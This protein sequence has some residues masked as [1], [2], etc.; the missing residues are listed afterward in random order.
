MSGRRG[1][2]KSGRDMDAAAAASLPT[3]SSGGSD[4]TL[5]IGSTIFYT[6][7]LAKPS[8]TV[9]EVETV[10][11]SFD[12]LT[13]NEAAKAAFVEKLCAASGRTQRTGIFPF[14]LVFGQADITKTA[15]ACLKFLS[16]VLKTRA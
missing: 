3:P 14:N 13:W 15:I 7:L 4:P 8:L 2:P 12:E 16:D 1:R 10:I 6:E 9:E 5:P 11:D